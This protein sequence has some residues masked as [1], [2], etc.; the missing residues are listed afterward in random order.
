MSSSTS[1]SSQS[2]RH[3]IC[4][5]SNSCR[6]RQ[7]PVGAVSILETSAPLQIPPPGGSRRPRGRA[8]SRLQQLLLQTA[9]QTESRRRERRPVSAVRT[10][11]MFLLG[12]F[13]FIFFLLLGQQLLINR[14]IVYSNRLRNLI[15]PSNYKEF[16]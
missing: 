4:Y 8:E 16:H 7:S 9:E 13:F 1:T 3:L 11:S 10:R 2:V 14:Q 6:S 15:K 5:R 12:F